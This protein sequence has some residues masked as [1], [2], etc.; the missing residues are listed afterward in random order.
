MNINNNDVNPKISHGT[1][2][3]KNIFDWYNEYDNNNN[4]NINI[5]ANDFYKKDKYNNLSEELESFYRNNISNENI[6]KI[7]FKIK[8]IIL[9]IQGVNNVE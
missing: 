9:L 4:P 1:N 7:L 2:S 5:N 6:L 8:D 3:D